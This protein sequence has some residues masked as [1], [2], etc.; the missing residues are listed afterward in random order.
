MR[1]V[2]LVNRLKWSFAGNMNPHALELGDVDNDGDIEFVI[3]NLN[4]EMA[5]FKGECPLGSP[6]FTCQDLGTITCIAIGDVRNVGKNSIVV[7]NAEGHCHI[8]DI[9]SPTTSQPPSQPTT[10]PVASHA[11]R[12]NLVDE[13]LRQGRRPSDSNSTQGFRKM[14]S[15]TEEQPQR[16]PTEG[17]GVEGPSIQNLQ[18]SKVTLKVPVNV[19]K[20]LIA[21]IDGDGLNELIL[22]RTDRILHSFQLDFQSGTSTDK[23]DTL[24]PSS[25]TTATLNNS[26][27]STLT[28][29]IQSSLSALSGNKLGSK[30]NNEGKELKSHVLRKGMV[31]K[32][33][34]SKDL[35]GSTKSKS[36]D[37]LLHKST[38]DQQ[39]HLKDKDMWVFDGQITSLTTTTYPD[40]PNEPILLVAQ[41]GNTFTIID[42]K[43]N[44]LNRDFTPQHGPYIYDRRQRETGT[45]KQEE[46]QE[47]AQES[48]T[49]IVATTEPTTSQPMDINRPTDASS[50]DT[51]TSTIRTLL[52]RFAIPNDVKVESVIYT[53]EGVHDDN[54]NSESDNDTFN[55]GLERTNYVIQDWS[56]IDGDDIMGDDKIGAV[57][58][59]IV[60]G[61]RHITTDHQ[62]SGNEIGMLS[63]D[64]KFTVYDLRTKKASQQDLFVTHKLFS[65]ATLDV[66]GT[67]ILPKSLYPARNAPLYFAGSP[68]QQTNARQQ[69]QNQHQQH[70]HQHQH[71]RTQHQ[72]FTSRHPSLASATSSPSSSGRAMATTATTTAIAHSNTGSPSFS[73]SSKLSFT[74][75]SS[76]GR[77]EEANKPQSSPAPPS[78]Q[79]TLQDTNSTHPQQQEI[80]AT[81]ATSNSGFSGFHVS[82][83][84]STLSKSATTKHGYY[85]DATST[86]NNIGHAVSG[87]SRRDSLSTNSSSWSDLDQDDDDDEGPNCDLFVA[88]A[89]NGVTY[90]I[91]WSQ[92]TDDTRCQDS[93]SSSSSRS[94]PSSN[95]RFQLV[96]FAF[97][98]RV[99]AFTAGLYAVAPGYNVPCLFYVDFEDQIF[100]YFDVRITPGKVSGFIDMIDDDVEEALDRLLGLEDDLSKA[101][102]STTGKQQ[103]Q[104]SSEEDG[105]QIDLGD[106]WKG[107]MDDSTTVDSLTLRTGQLDLTEFIHECLYDFDDMKDHLENDLF[108]F[109]HEHLPHT[110][111]NHSDIRRLSDLNITIEPELESEVS[112]TEDA[113]EEQGMFAYDDTRSS[114]S[115]DSEILRNWMDENLLRSNIGS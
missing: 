2:S 21:D 102:I 43:G 59:N 104:Q 30:S 4:G 90:L 37:G 91:D 85:D 51:S 63:M 92:R 49:A 67:P 19:N 8:F 58:T 75:P 28:S 61:K 71:Q 84:H 108:V 53:K 77:L 107:I 97:E 60:I 88:C 100:V 68:Q 64:G 16:P 96:K 55:S 57:A 13:Y 69:Q 50:K 109:E 52:N 34:R 115:S 113:M 80:L 82:D 98:G 73:T 42:Q 14:M 94:D 40:R 22:A 65:L 112:E 20:I 1:T 23:T 70:Q 72:A 78:S 101:M 99:C 11:Q 89:W 62:R 83:S 87:G 32:S 7:I 111:T 27:T 74:I 18:Q 31:W 103:Q 48:D 86:S 47:E 26:P 3:G 6:T 33:G 76:N 114:Q 29:T 105:Q 93:D 12:Q 66:S 95:I 81:A 35:K 15:Q 24:T 54:T 45:S 79:H 110:I 39:V 10:P 41:P 44:R 36:T 5:V 106:G 56:L 9:P 46:E 17:A 38:W 25:I